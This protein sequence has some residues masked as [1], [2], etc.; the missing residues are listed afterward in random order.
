MRPMV[1]ALA[2]PSPAS[3]IITSMA[4]IAKQSASVSPP[5]GRTVWSKSASRP[6]TETAPDDGAISPAISFSSVVFP[7]P[8][9]PTSPV[10]PE[11]KTASISLKREWPSAVVK[12]RPESVMV[13]CMK[14][15]LP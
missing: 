3:L 8:L 9:R 2:L 7:T 12:D 6:A 4:V 1:S 5:S 10:S 11:P 15:V 13:A 14:R